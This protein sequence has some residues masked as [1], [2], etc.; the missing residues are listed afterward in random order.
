MAD[1]NKIEVR[2]V[3]AEL[4]AADDSKFEIRGLAAGYNSISKDL[5]GFREVIRKGAFAR[6][7][8]SNPDVKCL[9][10]HDPNQIL[11]RTKSGTLKLEDTDKGLA[12]RCQLD[13][14][15]TMHRDLYSAIKRGDIDEC[16]FAFACPEGGD[17]FDEVKDERSGKRMVLR[18][19]KDVDLFDVSAVTN[20]AYGDGATNVSARSFD[21]TLTKRNDLFLAELTAI[22]KQD[23]EL[24]RLHL[25]RIGAEIAREG[26]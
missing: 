8:K 24:L 19:L 26:K 22:E 5:G 18:T 3:C 20:P 13:K 12:F 9:F 2:S 25:A 21:Y 10:N 11:G 23:D 6:S 1:K 4:R 14:D 15:S 16:S 7:L 17:S